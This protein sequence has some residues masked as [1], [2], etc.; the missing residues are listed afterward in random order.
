MTAIQILGLVFGCIALFF[1]LVAGLTYFK[2]KK[3]FSIIDES[4][5]ESVASF[6]EKQKRRVYVETLLAGV[7]AIATVVFAIINAI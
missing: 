5:Y 6:V 3:L 7:F 2:I 4:Q 1:S